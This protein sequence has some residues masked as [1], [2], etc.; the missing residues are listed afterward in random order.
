ML[1]IQVGRYEREYGVANQVGWVANSPGF[2]LAMAFC[3]IKTNSF[4]E[5]QVITFAAD[6]RLIRAWASR[7][8]TIEGICGFRL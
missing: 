6:V 4:K 3:A 1:A 5:P 7:T 2:M 8:C